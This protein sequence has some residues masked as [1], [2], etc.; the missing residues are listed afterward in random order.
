[1]KII[2]NFLAKLALLPVS[3]CIF[4]RNR[5]YSDDGNCLEAHPQV[6][7][8]KE[9]MHEMIAVVK[10]NSKSQPAASR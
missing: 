7:G 6:N 1:M 2:L 3:G 9:G 8:V 10:E 4:P 5:D